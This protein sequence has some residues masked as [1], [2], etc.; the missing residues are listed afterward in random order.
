MQ[1]L[2][3]LEKQK[4]LNA[5]YIKSFCVLVVKFR[6][7]LNIYWTSVNMP[8]WQ[9]SIFQFS[10]LQNGASLPILQEESED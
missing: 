7:V 8:E 2:Y 4:A 10:Y 3:L 6:G 5:C 1:A 9:F